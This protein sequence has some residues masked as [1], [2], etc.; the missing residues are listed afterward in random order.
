MPP[1]RRHYATDIADDAFSAAAFTLLAAIF[2]VYAF[3]SLK[4][5]H[6]ALIFAALRHC[7]RRCFLSP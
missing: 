7:F 3:S 4:I 5:R 2:F 1:L 6:D